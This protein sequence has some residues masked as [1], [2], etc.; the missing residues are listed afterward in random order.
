M[1]FSDRVC[2]IGDVD[3]NVHPITTNH[4]FHT[5]MRGRVFMG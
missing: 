3:G 5:D 4:H 1:V 2:P